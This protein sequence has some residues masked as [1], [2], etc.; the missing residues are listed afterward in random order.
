MKRKSPGG[1]RGGP[2]QRQL[3]A[4]ELVRHALVDILRQEDL[5][6]PEL[7]GVSVT[8]GE[9]RASPDLKH[10]T[11]FVSALGP[12]DPRAVAAALTRSRG[13]LRGRLARMI[14]LRFTPDGKLLVVRGLEELVIVD[15]DGRDVRRRVEALAPTAGGSEDADR[16]A[17]CVEG[18]LIV[19]RLVVARQD[20]R[21]P[22][23]LT[24]ELVFSPDGTR[25]AQR[26]DAV[27]R[28]H[29]LDGPVESA[30]SSSAPERPAAARMRPQFGSAP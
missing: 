4:G 9:V 16:L 5:R 26:E 24:D 23:R 2:S 20:D 8:I 22:C 11:A 28:V 7:Q 19:E 12:G 10:M 6:D 25:L 3:R 15:V 14:D 13:F 1:D 29:R 27:V 18:R 17:R 21:G 30:G